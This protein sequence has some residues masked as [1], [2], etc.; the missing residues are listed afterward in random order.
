M[1]ENW[2][3]K[4]QIL[5]LKQ[6]QTIYN[7]PLGIFLWDL[8]IITEIQRLGFSFINIFYTI[9]YIFIILFA[10]YYEGTL[11]FV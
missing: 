6:Y 4:R 9:P 8:T 5:S 1:A 2:F 11:K 10:D 7:V 3:S